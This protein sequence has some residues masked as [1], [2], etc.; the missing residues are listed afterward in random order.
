[1]ATV[2]AR[3]HDELLEIK[4]AHGGRLNPDDVWRF[5]RDHPK[6][7]LHTQYPWDVQKAAQDCWRDISRSL[8]RVYL[9]EYR[10][11]PRSN[12]VVIPEFTS[13]STERKK[14]RAS[15]VATVEVLRRP[16]KREQMLIDT[17]QRLLSIKE[18]AAFAEL[19]A[20]AKAIAV[21]AGRYIPKKA[22]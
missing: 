6:S 20:V 8:I 15:Y 10:E 7:A 2:R 21:V 13:L 22:A 17:I 12:I 5:A 19:K 16:Q 18:V 11:T 1:M 3:I 9:I 14:G 4:R